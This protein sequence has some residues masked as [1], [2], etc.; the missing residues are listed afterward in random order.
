MA[1]FWPLA[2]RYFEPGHHLA[3]TYSVGL[4]EIFVPRLCSQEENDFSC[5]GYNTAAHIVNST[6]NAF[7]NL[8]GV[9]DELQ[10]K[11][12]FKIL[13]PFQVTR[14]IIEVES[15]SLSHN[16]LIKIL[17]ASHSIQ[18][19]RKNAQVVTGLQ[20]SCYKSVHK[21]STSCVRTACS[22]L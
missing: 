18:N 8:T 14:N 12:L 21:L 11:V 10:C 15:E 17:L 3:Q 20:T 2:A 9:C 16:A 19:T 1:C 22:Q 13:W 5:P 7:L 6:L 4:Q